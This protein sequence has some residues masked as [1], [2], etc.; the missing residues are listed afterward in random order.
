MLKGSLKWVVLFLAVWGIAMFFDLKQE[1]I[2]KA[3]MLLRLISFSF[4]VTSI[5]ALNQNNKKDGKK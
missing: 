2:Q 5:T 3:E 4:M 1:H